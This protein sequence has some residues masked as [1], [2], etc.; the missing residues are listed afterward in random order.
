MDEGIGGHSVFTG[1]LIAA[2]EDV[3]DFVSARILGL[4]LQQQVYGDAASRGH[5]QRP[6]VGEIYGTGDFVFV[7][8]AAKREERARSALEE[9]KK[10]L[11]ELEKLKRSA[12]DRKAEAHLREIERQQLIKKVALKQ[13]QLREEAA[14]RDTELRAKAEKERKRN[15]LDQERREKERLERLTHLRLQAEKLREEIGSPAAALGLE[16]AVA[17]VSRINETLQRLETD[18]QEEKERQLKPLTDYYAPKIESAEKIAPRDKMFETEA[19]YEARVAK[20]SALAGSLTKEYEAKA[21]AIKDALED[22]L[23]RQK[24]PLEEQKKRITDME[25]PLDPTAIKFELLKYVPEEEKFLVYLESKEPG[26]DKEA[27]KELFLTTELPFPKTKAREFWH[28]PDLLIPALTLI[29]DSMAAVTPKSTSFRTPDGTLY[30]GQ[31]VRQIWLEPETGIEFVWVPGGCYEMGCGGEKIW[32]DN[33]E[34][35]PHRICVDGYWISKFEVTQGQWESIKDSNPSFF[36]KGG[37]F[38][39]EQVS[40]VEAKEFTRIL[41]QK[42]SGKYTLRLPTEAEWEYAC[43]GG[44]K[45]ETY[46][47]IEEM[48]QV[49]WHSGDGQFITHP[50]GT[51][52]P[53]SFGVY[54]MNGNV[55]EWCEDTYESD[56]YSHHSPRNPVNVSEKF[57]HLKVQRGGSCDDPLKNVRCGNRTAYSLKARYNALGFRLVREP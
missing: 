8:D 56:A 17:E 5:V 47:T 51:K 54:D 44:N 15:L 36:K 20:Q 24:K 40:W 13:A 25:F 28:N 9:I 1:R 53:N 41:N 4:K 52:A 37:A 6:L 22:E 39:V 2:L 49:A 31:N 45:L 50:V 21:R 12:E 30:L 43:R 10:E 16:E 33:D 42:N 48:G 35:P 57:G 18:F 32:C 14:R 55:S 7:P 34:F 19:D 26:D 38:P 27:G 46:Q 29:V 11:A 23:A 3:D